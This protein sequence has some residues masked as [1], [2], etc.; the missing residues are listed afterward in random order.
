MKYFY[1]K[2][3]ISEKSAS[4][5]HYLTGLLIAFICLFFAFFTFTGCEKIDE[6]RYDITSR[7]GSGE[8]ADKAVKVVKDFFE[9]LIADDLD[10]AYEFVYNPENSTQTFDAFKKELEDTTQII[11]VEI[12]WVEVKNN[13]AIVGVDLMDTYDGEEKIYK[14]LEISLVKNGNQ[15]WKINFW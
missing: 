1:H 9:A 8:E 13:I 4:T 5:R 12:N 15:E 10:L 3:F 6:L 11:K 2:K 14:D 7:F